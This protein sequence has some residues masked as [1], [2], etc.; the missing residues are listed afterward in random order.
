MNGYDPWEASNRAY[1]NFGATL[2]DLANMD[3]QRKMDTMQQQQFDQGMSLANL[4]LQR[5]RD[6]VMKERAGNRALIDLYGTG[7]RATEEEQLSGALQFQAQQTQEIEAQKRKREGMNQFFTS[8]DS[9]KKAGATPQFLTEFTKLEMSKDPALAK[10]APFV[11]YMDGETMEITRDF[12]SGELKDPTTGQPM[13]AGKYAI[14][15]RAT[16]DPNNPFKPTSI[17]PAKADPEALL[18]KRFDQQMKLQSERESRADARLEKS[19]SKQGEIHSRQTRNQSFALQ[20]EIRND[21]T[22]KQANDT[23]QKIRQLEETYADGKKTGNYTGSDQV[24]GYLIN[25]VLDPDSVVMV[26]EF[27]RI[28][29]SQGV[30]DRI[31]GNLQSLATGGIKLDDR[32]RDALINTMRVFNQ[33]IQDRKA[34]RIEEYSTD[35]SALG[36]DPNAIVG[37]RGKDQSKSAGGQPGKGSPAAKGSNKINSLRSKYGIGAK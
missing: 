33:A 5:E 20:K 30:P 8:I 17:V 32:S 4:Q 31:V 10:I 18:D 21:K 15:G 37:T 36:I 25:K 27:Q 3:R 9:F 14:K 12:A 34:A 11:S 16:G 22:I 2:S 19:L 1:A 26:S 24:M 6:S 13:P 28:A 29:K 7:D 23:S 35:A